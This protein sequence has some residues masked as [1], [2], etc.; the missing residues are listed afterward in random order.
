MPTAP[1]WS[2]NP[3]THNYHVNGR[4]VAFDK[5]IDMA[6]AYADASG[7]V[8]AGLA[9]QV[10]TGALRVDHWETTMRQALK[11][12]YI[13]QYVVGRGGLPQMTFRDWGIIG[14]MVKD[15]Y[16][17]LNGFAADI[18]SGRLSEAQIQARARMYINAAHEA[19]ERARTEAFGMPRLPAYPGDGQT[20]CLTNCRCNWII[21]EVQDKD[22]K[23]TGWRATWRLNPADHC[24]DCPTNAEI[25]AP[26]FVPAGMS[27]KQAKA[28]HKQQRAAMLK[29]RTTKTTTASAWLPQ[30]VMAY[31]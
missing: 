5:I 31:E 6:Y 15:Q 3:K 20:A 9:S 1:R 13:N 27:D 7:D 19:F 12:Q 25:W 17:Y 18:A 16:H 28:W 24:G 14:N 2:Y 21:T 30:G 10:V 22:G 8:A 11:T 29:A 26:L 4:F 23:T